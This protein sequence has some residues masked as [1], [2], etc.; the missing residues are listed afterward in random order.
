MGTIKRPFVKVTFAVKCFFLIS[1][2]TLK[3]CDNFDLKTL[4][5]P[6]DYTAVAN[7]SEAVEKLEACM[8]IWIKQ[9]E[10]VTGNE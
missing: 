8:K 3:E 6:S 9:M 4:K 1:Q 5:G 7:N 10:Q 2:V